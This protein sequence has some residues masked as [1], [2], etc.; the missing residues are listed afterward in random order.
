MK[1]YAILIG[2]LLIIF[3]AV[4]AWLLYLSPGAR[5]KRCV[6][7]MAA[8][9][10]QKNTEALMSHVS[11]DYADP[12]GNTYDMM[13]MV[14]RDIVMPNFEDIN[15]DIEEIRVQLKGGGTALAAVKG[16]ITYKIKGVP[17]RDKYTDESPLAISFKKE[18]RQW[19]VVAFENID[20]N[21][22]EIMRD[23][24]DSIQTFF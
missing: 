16:R 8:A 14:L 18:G 11:K 13:N 15:C 1:R 20:F 4:A 19:R 9:L 10:E 22:N 6:R 7:A 2:I 21:V 23:Y 24:E 5:V 3:G 12:A 17:K